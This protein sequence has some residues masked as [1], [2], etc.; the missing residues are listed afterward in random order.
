M[1]SRYKIKN[2]PLELS[3]NSILGV[4]DFQSGVNYI[5]GDVNHDGMVSA[6]DAIAI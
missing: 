1:T 2:S 6:E 5:P 3:N 4:G